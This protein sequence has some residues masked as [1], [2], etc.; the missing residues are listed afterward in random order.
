MADLDV[1]TLI[2]LGLP[3]LIGSVVVYF[4]L[5]LM[6][7]RNQFGKVFF[8]ELI[9]NIVDYF[10]SPVLHNFVNQH[11][12]IPTILGFNVL[13]VLLSI[14]VY[15]FGFNLNWI[16]SLILVVVSTLLSMLLANLLATFVGP[17]P[18]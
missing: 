2:S 3:V 1:S 11:I 5:K 8:V 7:R 16:L 14:L 6:S 9:R 4:T 13:T 12:Q 10:V 18:L 15:K 17:L